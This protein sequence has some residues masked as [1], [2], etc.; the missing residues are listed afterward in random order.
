MI[1]GAPNFRARFLELRKVDDETCSPI[2]FAADGDLHL[3]RVAMHAVIRVPGR[4]VGEVVRGV[5]AE[6]IRKLH[7][8]HGMPISLCVCRLSRQRG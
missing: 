7:A 4:K 6:S 3:E 2:R 8:R 1:E 5:E